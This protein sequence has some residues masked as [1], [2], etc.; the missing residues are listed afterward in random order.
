MKKRVRKL[1]VAF[2]LVSIASTIIFCAYSANGAEVDLEVTPTINPTPI[3]ANTITPSPTVAPVAKTS[4]TPTLAPTTTPVPT[5][6][7]IPAPTA[8]NTPIP[9]ATPTPTQAPTETPTPT[10]E[11]D[12]GLSKSG[13]YDTYTEEE[14]ELLFRVVEAEVTGGDVESKS[15]VAS[16]IFNRLKEGWW[17]GDLTKNLMA[18]RQFAVVTNGRYLRVTITESTIKACEIA[19]EQDT[20][21]GALFFDST[22]GNSWAHNNRTFL[23]RDRVGHNFYK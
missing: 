5:S 22:D 8:T 13:L 23:F 7:P 21:Q 6:T 4:P 17:S 16:V 14:L 11:C 3:F 15:H 12:L 19:F 9:T 20:A 1:F 10:P 18:N 2:A